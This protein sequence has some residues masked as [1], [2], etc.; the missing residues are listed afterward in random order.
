MTSEVDEK[1]GCVKE[2]LRE[3]KRRNKKV[4]TFLF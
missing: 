4:K 2:R 1:E 3:R